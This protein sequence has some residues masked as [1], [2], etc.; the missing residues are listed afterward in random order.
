MKELV[1]SMMR[2]LT[3]PMRESLQK[4]LEEIS[5]ILMNLEYLS[6]QFQ[7]KE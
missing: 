7:V 4:Y 3:C 6:I 1:E 2:S 5:M